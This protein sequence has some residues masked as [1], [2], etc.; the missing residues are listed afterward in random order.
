MSRPGCRRLPG[1]AGLAVLFVA[2]VAVAADAPFALPEVSV[3]AGRV[4]PEPAG[5]STPAAVASD[6]RATAGVE[7]QS[8]GTATAQ[9]DLR[10]RG[11][12]FSGAGLALGGLALRNPQTEHFNAELPVPPQLLEPAQ[13]LTGLDQARATDGNLAGTV[14]YGF[15]PVES[16]CVLEAGIGEIGRD[17]QGGFLQM[18]LLRTPQLGTLGA[19]LFGSRENAAR[20]DGQPDNFLDRQSAGLHLQQRGVDEQADLLAATQWKRF[21]ARGFYGTPAAYPAA[22]ELADRLVL[23]SVRRGDPS[24]SFVRLTAAWRELDD[25][26]WLDRTR[27]GLYKNEHHSTLGAANLDGRQ[28]VDEAWGLRWRA[29]FADERIDS[30]YR[31]TFPGAG[32]GNHDRQRAGLALLPEWTRGGLRLTA[33]GKAA[34]FSD[35]RPAW[36]PAAGAEFRVA[37]RQSLFADYTETVRQPSF[38]ELNYNSPGSLGNQGLERQHDRS[39]E[40]G[41]RGTSAQGACDGRAA[42]FA[43]RS[44]NAVDWIKPTLASRWLATSLGTVDTVGCEAA[45]TWHP[46]RRTDLGV[47][48]ALLQKRAAGD[49]F[50]S[51]YVLDYPEHALK[52]TW[53]RELSP[54]CE[55][56]ILQGVQYQTGNP[57]RTS[58]RW[59]V[60]AACELRF[61]CLPRAGAE[62]VL[63]C[64]N[65]WGRRFET[66]PGQP[67]A[68]RSV[69]VA[70]V[71]A[72]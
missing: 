63:A 70:V 24:A 14:D 69:S 23:G 48:Y 58:G 59:A 13:V 60:P 19:S 71:A 10:I 15:A 62:L 18:P 53:R 22:E 43:T 25:E 27:P 7:L 55:V 46:D 66:F 52:L 32:L 31:G 56:R 35:D 57:V 38:T 67:A 21:G 41:W 12:S 61:R 36:L 39:L 4:L 6:L 33:G 5:A 49:V 54:L 44:A 3:T 51:R 72:W 9:T 30:V 1:A 8:Q 11:S 40:A 50:A 26:Y 65:L 68:G 16:R 45:G 47:G 28:A 29:E 2:F 20:T 42:V 37:A 17:W 34:V 64:D